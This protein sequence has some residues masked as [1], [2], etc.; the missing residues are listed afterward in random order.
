MLSYGKLGLT[1]YLALSL[2]LLAA[3]TT[4]KLW[5]EHDANTFA[6]HLEAES[7]AM[8]EQIRQQT[9]LAQYQQHLRQIE[10][11]KLRA[12]R[13]AANAQKQRT[14]TFW[15]DQYAKTNKSYDQSMMNSACK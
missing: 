14:C 10:Q 11:N 3:G 12:K 1:I 9:Q 6:S 15:R 7:A 2:S 4:F 13:D 8:T 5:L